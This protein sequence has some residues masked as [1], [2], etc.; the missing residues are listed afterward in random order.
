[1]VAMTGGDFMN[2]RQVQKV[3]ASLE[4]LEGIKKGCAP[5]KEKKKNFKIWPIILTKSS[6]KT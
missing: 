6:P 4:P 3:W 2:Y 5:K 1:M